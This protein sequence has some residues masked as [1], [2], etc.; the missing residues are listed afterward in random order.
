[1]KLSQTSKGYKLNHY[2]LCKLTAE[3]FLKDSDIVLFEYKIIGMPENPDVL[4]FKNGYST[5]YEIKCSRSDF[6]ADRK[7]EFRIKYKIKYWPMLHGF[8]EITQ[9]LLFEKHELQEFIKEYPHLGIRRYYVCEPGLID[10][11]ET[12][13]WGLYYFN[14]RFKLIKESKIFKRDLF[15]ENIF[16]VHALRFINNV[17]P[18]YNKSKNILI[19]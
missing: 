4:C 5:L 16:L 19:K 10:S 2:E 7:K 11:N 1:M 12:E 17:N 14:K 6:I 8:N 13:N 3:R 9:K 18:T 15:R